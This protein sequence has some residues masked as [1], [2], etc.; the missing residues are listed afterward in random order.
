[1]NESGLPVTHHWTLNPALKPYL[2]T[3]AIFSAACVAVGIVANI[4]SWNDAM[5]PFRGWSLWAFGLLIGVT[6]AG[7]ALFLWLGMLSYWWELSDK[8]EE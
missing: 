1:M 7:S 2:L 6:A 4:F 5:I 8:K 3:S